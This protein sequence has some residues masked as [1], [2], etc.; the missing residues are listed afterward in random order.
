MLDTETPPFFHIISFSMFSDVKGPVPVYSYPESISN[1]TQV[2]IAMKS[3]S[4]LMGEAVYQA[5]L[6][7][8]LRYFGILPFPDLNYVGLTYFFLNGNQ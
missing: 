8:D 7:D 1:E 6:S 2:E 3:V 5:G 4:L